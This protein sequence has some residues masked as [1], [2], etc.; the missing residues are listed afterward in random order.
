M[1]SSS[2]VLFLSDVAT[3]ISFISI[4]CPGCGQTGSGLAVVVLGLMNGVCEKWGVSGVLGGVFCG[5]YPILGSTR[6]MSMYLR[7]LYS[8]SAGNAGD[9]F[10]L[11]KLKI[12]NVSTGK[13]E[14]GNGKESLPIIERC[15]SRL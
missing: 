13:A 4:T 9:I 1:F 8:N 3:G 14:K 2:N 11:S 15:L 10:C 12:I 5:E 7:P 6:A